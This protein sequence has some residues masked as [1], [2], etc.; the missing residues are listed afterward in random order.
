MYFGRSI[1]ERP[2]SGKHSP[3][4]DSVTPLANRGF[5]VRELRLR[6][7][8][9]PFSCE[10][11]LALA[12]KLPVAYFFELAVMTSLH[13]DKITRLGRTRIGFGTQILSSETLR[14]LVD[15]PETPLYDR[16]S[17]TVKAGRT[18]LV[19]RASLEGR[20]G[21]LSV[22]YKRIKRKTIWKRLTS[23]VESNR[24]L[25][26]WQIGNW[27]LKNGISTPCP[28]AAIVPRRHA[29]DRN[30]YLVTQ[31]ID[32]ANDLHGYMQELEKRTDEDIKDRLPELAV[33][34]GRLL[35]KM[36]SFGMSHRDLKAGNFLVVEKSESLELYLIDLDGARL[37]RHLDFK[38]KARNLSRLGLAILPFRFLSAA[39]KLRFLKTYLEE[40]EIPFHEWKTW[41][42][43]I[44]A[45]IQ[46]RSTEKRKR[47]A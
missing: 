17:A 36:H 7:P 43:T 3:S 12:G 16:T 9:F 35:G 37:H 38:R 19:V 13:R 45:D 18:S 40:S 11:I 47:T 20:D 22:C 8:R 23:F 26:H 39:N 41:W 44:A 31:W 15:D 30:S 42:R 32:H 1:P 21:P 4:A 6:F 33:M 46:R 2:F 10:T 25:H 24:A 28:V 5:S 27:C 14:E 34:L 29:A